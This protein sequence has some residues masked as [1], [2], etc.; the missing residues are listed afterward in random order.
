M[1]T[2]LSTCQKQLQWTEDADTVLVLTEAM[3]F[4]LESCRRLCEK[5]QRQASVQRAA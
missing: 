4:D 5:F 3:L 2:H 1:L